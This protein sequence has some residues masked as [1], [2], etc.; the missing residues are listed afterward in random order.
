MRRAETLTPAEHARIGAAIREAESRTAGEIVCVVARASDGYFFHAAA[1]S[2]AA[3]LVAS[4]AVAFALEHLWIVP[5]LPLFAGAVLFAG[6]SLLMLLWFIPGLRLALV[7]RG[8]RYRAA[9]ENAVRQF[10]ARNI[11]RTAAR[12]GVLVFVSLAEAYAEVLADGGIDAEVEQTAWDGI[13]EALTAA[14][15]AGRLADGLV[16]AV[17]EAGRLLALHFPP[18]AQDRNELDDHVVE[19]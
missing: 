15:A 14:A 8:T 7:P 2:L 13:V 19:L 12:T 3:L 10:L 1:A 4:L 6:L 16:Q 11:H 17:A 5:R 18:A 9:H